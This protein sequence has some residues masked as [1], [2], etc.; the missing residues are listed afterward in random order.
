[1]HQRLHQHDVDH[2]GLVNNQ[3]VALE[4]VVHAAFEAA[5][6]RVHLQQTVDGL[7]LEAG[8]FLHPLGSPISRGTEPQVHALGR[9]D[10]QDGIDQVVWIT[11]PGYEWGLNG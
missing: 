2:R 1:L 10:A 8:G 3:Q 9:Q 4:R 6:G 11:P 5:G 7:G